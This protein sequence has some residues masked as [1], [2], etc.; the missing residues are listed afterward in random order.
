MFGEITTNRVIKSIGLVP[1]TVD[2]D[3]RL[4]LEVVLESGYRL[5]MADTHNQ[6]CCEIRIMHTAD[7]LESLIGETLVKVWCSDVEEINYTD[8]CREVT[9]LHIQTDRDTAVVESYNAHNGYYGGMHVTVTVYDPAGKCV[10]GAT[11]IEG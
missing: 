5:V 1:L 8:G 9:F 6:N 10:A 11:L 2:G 4:A 7:N 3:E